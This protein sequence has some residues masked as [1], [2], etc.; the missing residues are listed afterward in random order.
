[1]ST[2]RVERDPQLV[3]VATVEGTAL[4]SLSSKLA[5]RPDATRLVASAGR[6]AIVF[7]AV[8]VPYAASRPL[9]PVGLLAVGVMAAIWLVTLRGAFAAGHQILGLGLSGASGSATGFVAVAALNPLLPGLGLAVP[10]L[11]GSFVGVFATAVAWEWVVR[12]TAAG[13][14]RVLVVGTRDVSD[15]LSRELDR[16]HAHQIELVARVGDDS[17]GR[18]QDS[19]PHLGGLAG[20]TA[21]VQAQ[22][23]DLVVL[24]D[25]RTYGLV[26]D[27]LLA[28]PGL[29]SRVVG[30]AGFLEH[31]LGRVPV[32]EVTPAWFMSIIH[33]RQPVY[34]RCTKRAFDIV[35]AAFGLIVASPVLLASAAVVSRTH[36]PVLYRQIRLGE[37]GRPFTIYKF[38]TM[39]QNAEEDGRPCFACK[40][41]E[42]VIRGGRLL[43]RTHL[44]ELPQLWNVLKGDMS[45]V[46]PRPERPEF[47]E[48]LEEAV[49]FW[50]RRL[51]IKPG[52]TG[53]AQIRCGYAA[54]CEEM[55]DKLSY[56]L[57]YLRN[58]SLAVDVAICVR[59]FSLQLRTLLPR[60]APVGRGIG[61]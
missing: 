28:V 58:R 7:L 14:Q 13:R 37:G 38:R 5:T 50:T 16:A 46:G 49:P 33:V 48:G 29:R 53:W 30:L 26:A 43:R 31:T 27:R 15:A 25:D 2:L 32:Q 55:A 59:T 36:G 34:G 12:H 17:G 57:W 19:V 24:T 6:P 42:R 44:D 10:V 40:D 45:V 20:L 56:D 61:R 4:S 54:D 11:F 60:W 9:T 23:P 18:T 47:A 8:L 35:A 3:R 41:D 51:L 52:V 21:V 1:M 39:V 22:R